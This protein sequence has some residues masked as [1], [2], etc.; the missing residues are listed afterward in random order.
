MQFENIISCS[1]KG[2]CE[3]ADGTGGFCLKHSNKETDFEALKESRAHLCN[4]G[5]HLGY[6]TPWGFSICD[7]ESLD[8]IAL[9]EPSN[10]V[11]M[12]CQSCGSIS[13]VTVI[14][15][16]LPPVPYADSAIEQNVIR[17]IVAEW[18][19]SQ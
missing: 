16:M 10:D 17:P 18:Y 8:I 5:S 7:T 9:I 15:A 19:A 1:E 11:S 6:Y 13:D 14:Q 4:C 3:V 12:T 2:C